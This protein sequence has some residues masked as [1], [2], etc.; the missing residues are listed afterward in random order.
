MDLD[1]INNN[2]KFYKLKEKTLLLFEF[3]HK[4]YKSNELWLAFLM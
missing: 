4:Y 3:K 2:L 1:S